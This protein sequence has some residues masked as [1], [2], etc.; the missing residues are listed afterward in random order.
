MPSGNPSVHPS[1]RLSAL[2]T[3]HRRA[4]AQTSGMISQMCSDEKVSPPS[5][6][7]PYLPLHP[8]DVTVTSV[9]SSNTNTNTENLGLTILRGPKILFI[10]AG[11]LSVP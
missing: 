8:Q 11:V 5:G 7:M 2:T 9:T 10:I 3:P 4:D 1:V 6:L